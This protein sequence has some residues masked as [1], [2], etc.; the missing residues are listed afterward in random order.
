MAQF[1]VHRVANGSF[2]VDCQS[3]SLS[4]LGTRVAA[5][6]MRCGDVP[7]PATRLHPVLIFRDEAYLLATH[8]LTAIPTRDLGRP[9]LSLETERYTIQSA[10]DL[11]LSGV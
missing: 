10:L 4:H 11:L 8:L 5:P 7:A 3:D 2:V 1:D 6:L 9:I